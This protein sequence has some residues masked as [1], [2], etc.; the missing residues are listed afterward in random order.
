[1]S[2]RWVG[3]V[4]L[5]LG[6]GAGAGAL[7][8]WLDRPPPAALGP[9][10]VR[11]ELDVHHS[12]FGLD[13]LRVHAGTTVELVLRNTDPIHHELIVG[14]E[15]VHARH[16][17]GHERRHPPVPGEVSVGPNATAST[18]YTFDRPGRV[19]FACHLPGHYEHGMRGWITVVP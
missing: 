19:E 3:A 13:D 8:D 5:A 2:V 6:V 10:L 14:D 9:G 15:A 17:V 16:A 18:V 4:A 7:T 12:L 11:V 1:M